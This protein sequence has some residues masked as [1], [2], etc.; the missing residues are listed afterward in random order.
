MTID[1]LQGLDTN[2]RRKVFQYLSR[3]FGD[4]GSAQHSAGS[5]SERLWGLLHR[6]L[7]I[8]QGRRRPLSSH[9]AVLGGGPRAVAKFT[10]QA[11]AVLSFFD[12]ALPEG[13]PAVQRDA[14]IVVCLALLADWLRGHAKPATPKTLLDMAGHLPIITDAAFPGYA[15]S[16]LL[17]LIVPLNPVRKHDL[18]PT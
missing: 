3:E 16:K 9:I 5:E 18:S 11:D 13:I 4:V 6:A 17:H 14:V 8:P 12:S 2:E 15:G 7:D 1:T 10:A